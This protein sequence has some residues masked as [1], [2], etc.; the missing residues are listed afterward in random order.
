MEIA[1][2]L[3]FRTWRVAGA[4]ESPYI[5]ASTL[6]SQSA[7]CTAIATAVYSASAVERAVNG[8]FAERHPM[9]AP[10]RST[11][12]IPDVVVAQG[13]AESGPVPGHGGAKE[14]VKILK[15]K[16]KGKEKEEM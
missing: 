11:I 4:A 2:L 5:S 10:L 1:A 13:G 8:C 6:E 15:E 9:T 12:T 3:S 14:K 16:A 7:S